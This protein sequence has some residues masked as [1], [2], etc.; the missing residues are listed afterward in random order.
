[1]RNVFFQVEPTYRALKLFCQLADSD[2]NKIMFRMK[3]GNNAHFH[4]FAQMAA[5]A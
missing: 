4:T 5:R 1:M 2:D 3:E